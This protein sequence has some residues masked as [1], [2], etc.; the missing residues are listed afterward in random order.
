VVLVA[1]CGGDASQ[2]DQDQ[3]AAVLGE[4]RQVQDAGDAEL[5]CQEVYVIQEPARPGAE[6]GAEENGAESPA[7][8]EAAFRAANARLRSDVHELTTDVGAI[9]VDGDSA[10]AIVHTSLRRS[11]GSAL[12]QDVP[13][14]LVRTPGGWRIRIADEG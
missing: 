10:T 14:D 2:S 11:D 8:C 1:G 6:A 3:I 9:E 12:A 13:Y 4:L 5:A 7:A